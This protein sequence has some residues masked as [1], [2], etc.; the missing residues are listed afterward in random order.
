MSSAYQVFLFAIR[1]VIACI[2]S[3]QCMNVC[4]RSHGSAQQLMPAAV[5]SADAS[6]MLFRMLAFKWILGCPPILTAPP[7]ASWLP[8]KM[9]MPSPGVHRRRLLLA[10][11]PLCLH[12][13]GQPQ[14][15]RVAEASALLQ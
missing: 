6:H 15:S 2:S 5:S 1:M 7:L 11:V 9:L 12:A 8:I 10:S 13:A 14:L 3:A 4:L